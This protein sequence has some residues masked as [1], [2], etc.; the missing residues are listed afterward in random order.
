VLVRLV[1]LSVTNV[2]ALLRLLA[3]S[4][5]DKDVEILVLRHQLTVL[6]RQLGTARPRFPRCDR[7]FLAAFLHWLPR[8]VLSRVPL[9]VRAETVLRWHREL[10]ARRHAARSRPGRPGRPRSIRSVR[11]LVLRLARGGPVPGL[12]AHPRRTA[13]PRHQGRC[14]HGAGDPQAGRDRP[15]ARPGLHDLGQLPPLAG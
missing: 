1:Y 11:L 14:L 8:S 13:R 5:R 4:D 15:R 10:L 12:P 6:Q 9:P 7:A 3:A 2:F